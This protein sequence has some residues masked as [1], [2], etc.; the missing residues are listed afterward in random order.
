[1]TGVIGVNGMYGLYGVNG[2]PVRGV[3]AVNLSMRRSRTVV[4]IPGD[5]KGSAKER[6]GRVLDAADV[7]VE[8]FDMRR[9]GAG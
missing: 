8:V 6:K 2:T 7:D 9:C 1:M 4:W 5:F 3:P